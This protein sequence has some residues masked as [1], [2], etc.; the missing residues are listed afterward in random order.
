MVVGDP[1]RGIDRLGPPDKREALLLRPEAVHRFIIMAEPG[2][3]ES[4]VERLTGFSSVERLELVDGWAVTGSVAEAARV[5]EAE[6]VALVWYLHRDMA[7][8]YVNT[9]RGLAFLAQADDGRPMPANISLGPPTSLMPLSAWPDEPM[10]RATL[11]AAEA[12]VVVVMAAGNY[13]SPDGA[14]DGWINPWC[15]PEW[16]ICVGAATADRS[17][18]FEL[19]ARGDPAR[20]ETWPD[21]VAHGVDSVGPW[22]TTVPKP[23]SRRAS[24]EANPI[25]TEKVAPEDRH[26]YTIASGTSFAAPKVSAAAAQ[27]IHFLN[28]AIEQNGVADYGTPIFELTMERARWDR[29][30]ALAPRLSGQIIAADGQEVQVRYAIDAPWKLVKQLLIDT[31]I[32]MPGF[33]RHEVGAG[34]V[35]PDH[36]A[37]QFGKF[38]AV[39]MK[40]LPV[41]VT[42]G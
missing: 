22:P 32:E 35:D 26:L 30:A 2:A 14:H 5:A 3:S 12:G 16:V 29:L 40:L 13:G 39:D 36:V 20:P 25:F 24:D 21:L 42:E 11:R 33:H 6:G 34:F 7:S 15:L 1:V 41:R 27:V 10:H 9:I 8:V 37:A 38:E 31:A 4:I 17:R 18:L 28:G 19:S 23:A